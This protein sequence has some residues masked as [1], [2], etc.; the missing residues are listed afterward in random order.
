MHTS[1]THVTLTHINTHRQLEIVVEPESH[2]SDPSSDLNRPKDQ[3]DWG[4][5]DDDNAED[6]GYFGG[7]NANNGGNGSGDMKEHVFRPV[8]KVGYIQR[9]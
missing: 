5:E 8:I 2:I 6:E 3:H 1:P 7:A 9:I 4:E